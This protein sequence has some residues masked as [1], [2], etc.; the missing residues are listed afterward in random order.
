MVWC[1]KEKDIEMFWIGE[2]LKVSG[3]SKCIYLNG[4]I[5]D[6]G[7]ESQHKFL[8]LRKDYKM[9]F[10]S[11]M[12]YKTTVS[13]QLNFSTWSN[14]GLLEHLKWKHPR[15]KESGIKF[16]EEFVGESKMVYGEF[17]GLRVDVQKLQRKGDL[18]KNLSNLRN[19]GVHENIMGF[20][21]AETNANIFL[22]FYHRSNTKILS[23]L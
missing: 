14:I 16:Y 2:K 9:K 10:Y 23:K 12:P 6:I 5:G 15:Y 17:Q 18:S 13:W 19:L 4:E 20:I 8:I 7:E 22:N 21:K 3:K 1:A 11:T